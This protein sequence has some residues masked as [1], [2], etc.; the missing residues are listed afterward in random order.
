LPPKTASL[1]K[2]ARHFREAVDPA[3]TGEEIKNWEGTFNFWSELKVTQ[4]EGPHIHVN[5]NVAWSAAVAIVEGK[6][7]DG[8]C[9]ERAHVRDGRFPETRR[10]VAAGIPHP[11]RVPQ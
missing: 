9:G 6:P 7:K 2:R 3:W 1:Y 8:Q 4:A 11:S 10:R 5:G